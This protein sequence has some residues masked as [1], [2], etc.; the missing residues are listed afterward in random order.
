MSK[1]RVNHTRRHRYGNTCFARTSDPVYRNVI[2]ITTDYVRLT[3]VSIAG[4]CKWIGTVVSTLDHGEIEGEI[5][6]D[7]LQPDR[8]P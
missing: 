1:V 8:G 6:M 3:A 7:K 4:D 5:L 2:H